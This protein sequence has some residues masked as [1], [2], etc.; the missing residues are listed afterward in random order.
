MCHP[1]HTDDRALRIGRTPQFN[2]WFES[3]PAR[4]RAQIDTRISAIST[5][6]FGDSTSLGD[7]LFELR[8]RQGMRVYYSLRRTARFE[9]AVLW[10]GFKGTQRADIA[11][12]KRLKELIY[13]HEKEVHEG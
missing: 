4:A 10:G 11:K 9:V 7:G 5:G 2:R 12:A 6:H 8:W 3:L 13:E 1:W